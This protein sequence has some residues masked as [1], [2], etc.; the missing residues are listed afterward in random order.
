MN[1]EHQLKPKLAWSV[2]QKSNEIKRKMVEEQWLQLKRTFLFFYWVEWWDGIKISCGGGKW[3][4]FCLVEGL[5][6]PP[7]R[8]A[9]YK[10]WQQVFIYNEQGTCTSHTS[11][12]K[13]TILLLLDLSTFCVTRYMLIYGICYMVYVFTCLFSVGNTINS[14]HHEHV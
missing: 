8:K 3:A 2:F 4:N 1:T 14:S 6:H 7:V 10:L 11:C 5:L 12:A 9:L 13:L